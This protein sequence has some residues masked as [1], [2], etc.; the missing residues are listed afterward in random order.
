M[1]ETDKVPVLT[2]YVLVGRHKKSKIRRYVGSCK[3][4]KKKIKDKD[5]GSGLR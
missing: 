3:K 5:I 4:V 2:G 1:N